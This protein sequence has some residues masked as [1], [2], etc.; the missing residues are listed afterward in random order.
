MRM[1][2]KF[3]IV[4]AAT[5]LIGAGLQSA[6]AY[7]PMPELA[8]KAPAPSTEA[9]GSYK[10]AQDTHKF[11]FRGTA[12]ISPDPSL[13][14]QS[15]SRGN[16]GNEVRKGKRNRGNGNNT[17]RNVGLGVAAGIIGLGIAAAAADADRR[18]ER[19][20]RRSCRRV[21]RRCAEDF[22]WETRRWFRC[23]ERRGC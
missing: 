14:G 4:S 11:R 20:G 2:K 5:L 7:T 19:G 21:E 13:A 6:S 3:V 12:K 15:D 10:V 23:V 9:D 1:F 17:G 8:A 18:N 16:N 22:G